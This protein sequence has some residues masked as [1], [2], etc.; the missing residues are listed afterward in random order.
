MAKDLTIRLLGRPQITKDDQVGYQ[1]ISRQYVVEGY[2]ASYAGINDTGNPLF[3]PVGTE[4]EEFTDHYLVNQ[5]ISPKQG[6]VDS[7]YLNRE[8]VEIRDSFAQESVVCTADLRRVRRTYVVLRADHAKGYSPVGKQSTW[9]NHPVNGGGSDPWAYAPHPVSETPPAISYD[10]PPEY[11]IGKTPQLGE[12]QTL[13]SAIENAQ[14]D[15]VNAAIWLPGSAQVSFSRPGFDVWSVEWVN[16]N[17]P[18][19]ISGTKQTGRTSFSMPRG[20]YFDSNGLKISNLQVSGGSSSYMQVGTFNFFVTSE[21]IPQYFANY[22]SSVGSVSPSVM[23]DLTFTDYDGDNKSYTLKQAVPNA[24][25]Q[26]GGRSLF[27]PGSTG[28][29]VKVADISLNQLNFVGSFPRAMFADML[30]TQNYPIFQGK[31]LKHIGGSIS[32]NN[33]YQPSSQ[34]AASLSVKVAPLFTS[35]ASAEKKKIWKVS[36]TYVG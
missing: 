34:F 2:R 29:T 31:K 35:S 3:L 13:Y 27:F 5:R 26:D 4:D 9:N 36:I 24:M 30:D 7:A 28:G 22:W 14:S 20:V 15:G 16:H 10:L 18:Y 19:W 33:S 32:W 11:T 12:N 21:N 17:V 23:V 25:F 6:S 1:R 8:Y